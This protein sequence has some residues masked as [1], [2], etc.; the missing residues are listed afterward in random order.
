MFQQFINCIICPNYAIVGIFIAL[1]KLHF[2]TSYAN[3]TINN[4]SI[5]LRLSSGISL[6]IIASLINILIYSLMLYYYNKKYYINKPKFILSLKTEKMENENEDVYN[7]YLNVKKNY[8]NLEISAFRLNKKYI[9]NKSYSNAKEIFKNRNKDNIEFN[10]S[11][12]YKGP[13]KVEAVKDVSLGFNH[14]ECFAL[15][16]PN[17]SGKST[18][19]DMISSNVSSTSGYVFYNG[20]ESY[21]T[22]LNNISLGYCPQS[23]TYWKELTVQDNIEYMLTLHGYPVKDVKKY[24]TQ[25]IKYFKFQDDQYTK[26]LNLSEGNKRKLCLLL[27]LIGN[28]K[29]I[30]L[31]EPTAGM[32]PSTRNHILKILKDY[33]E[34][35][36]STIILTSHSME[37]AEYLCDRLAILKDGEIICIGTPEYIK[38]KY[39]NSYNLEI[40]SKKLKKFHQKI[41]EEENLI[42]NEYKKEY[43]SYDRINYE[44]PKNQIINPGKIFEVMENCKHKG[45]IMDY[46][47]GQTSLE[48]IFI[49]LENNSSKNNTNKN[50]NNNNNNNK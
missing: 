49:N 37:E 18:V 31:D 14:N 21:L 23:N 25:Y 8:K 48:H 16:G 35:N 27:A 24:T 13:C 7:E 17:G 40:H 2:F 20:V 5:L 47:F 10:D 45:I 4:F 43:K 32:D 30:I 6:F 3:K 12:L 26:I 34:I 38:N 9:V 1:F 42:G 11:I 46:N 50:I 15:L 28:P 19:L 22:N 29:I 44:I 33:K 41:I 36:E 39:G